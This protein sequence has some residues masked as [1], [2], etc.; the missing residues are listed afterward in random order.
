[1]PT[2]ADDEDD[3]ESQS[4]L[5]GIDEPDRPQGVDN[6]HQPEREWRFP[7]DELPDADGADGD[8]EKS[9]VAGTMERRQPL[10]PGEIALENAVFVALGA[11]LVLGLIVGAVLG[12]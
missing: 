5:E 11:V 10:E 7:V 3:E 9:N 8:G 2:G 1:M 4:V 6:G 12:L